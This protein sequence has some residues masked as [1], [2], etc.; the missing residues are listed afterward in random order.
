MIRRAI[1]LAA[2][3]IAAPVATAEAGVR[4]SKGRYVFGGSTY[5]ARNFDNFV[6]PVTLI[7][8]DGGGEIT[9]S[10]VG[11]HLTDDWRGWGTR[12]RNRACKSPQ[13]V[14]FPNNSRTEHRWAAPSM[15][16][17]TDPA[18]TNQHHGRFWNDRRHAEQFGGNHP[19]A[20]E[21]LLG[22]VHKERVASC[23]RTG[24]PNAPLVCYPHGHRI[25]GDFDQARRYAVNAMLHVTG[26]WSAE[27]SHYV[28][29]DWGVHPTAKKWYDGKHHSRVISKISMEH[30]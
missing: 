18:C 15:Y 9:S 13:Y 12:R 16:G 14:P 30:R 1:C 26:R 5:A 24:I 10:R 21:F 29:F 7:F 27:R 23:K 6:N 22:A 2:V 11:R 25:S 4:D 8:K 17:S 20:G 3:A 19:S 28:Q